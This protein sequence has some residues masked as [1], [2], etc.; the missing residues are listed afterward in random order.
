MIVRLPFGPLEMERLD[1]RLGVAFDA[2]RAGH[3]EVHDERL[4]ALDRRQEVFRPP[5]QG[6]DP[7]TGQTFGEAR[8]EGNA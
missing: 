4:A 2:K 7:L 5:R 6:V 8:G 1:E 3:A